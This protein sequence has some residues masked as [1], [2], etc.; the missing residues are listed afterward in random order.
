MENNYKIETEDGTWLKIINFP[1]PENA[2]V[3]G[4]S[5]WVKVVEGNEYE[6]VGVLDNAPVFCEE[7]ELGDMVRYHNGTDKTKPEY[8]GLAAPEH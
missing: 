7:V 1:V 8:A 6:G 2:P 3:A 5:M 4:E